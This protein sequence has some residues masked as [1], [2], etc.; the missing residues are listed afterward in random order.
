MLFDCTACAETFILKNYENIIFL[1]CKN[2]YFGELI[3]F[4]TY[5]KETLG[6]T[7]ERKLSL[8]PNFYINGQ[9]ILF[10]EKN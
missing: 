4:L 1:K 9:Y 8:N 7:T 5:V 6:L 3:F 2:I 10:N